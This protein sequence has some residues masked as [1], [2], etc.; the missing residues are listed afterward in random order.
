MNS[1]IHVPLRESPKVK[2]LWATR[3]STDPRAPQ[4]GGLTIHH[5]AGNQ[6]SITLRGDW[7]KPE[8]FSISHPYPKSPS[9]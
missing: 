1:E 5:L 3:P 9:D 8:R 6:T 2:S 4:S 7:V